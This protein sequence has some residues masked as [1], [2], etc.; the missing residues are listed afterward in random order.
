MRSRFSIAVLIAALLTAALPSI[1]IGPGAPVDV[2]GQEIETT[3]S[4]QR[5]LALPF[6]A[7]HVALRWMGAPEAHLMIAFGET[8]EELGEA[9]DVV[10]DDDVEG[11]LGE[12]SSGVIWTGGAR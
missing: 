1:R 8:R 10:V 4:H 9:V 11:A 7:S 2:K 6:E 5:I 12:V 3:V